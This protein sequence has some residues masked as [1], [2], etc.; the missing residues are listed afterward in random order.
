M[1]MRL[2]QFCEDKRDMVLFL[3]L[4]GT[5]VQYRTFTHSRRFP[6][7]YTA[8]FNL[9]VGDV[10]MPRLSLI[11]MNIIYIRRTQ[12]RL[13]DMQIIYPAPSDGGLLKPLFSPLH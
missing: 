4:V 3:L 13:M 11:A 1:D 12:T 2:C 8:A 10:H 7:M 6:F 5:Y 9:V